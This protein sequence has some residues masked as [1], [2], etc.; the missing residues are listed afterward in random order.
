MGLQVW[1][2]GRRR[3][4]WAS[5]F[6]SAGAGAFPNWFQ[7]VSFLFSALLTMNGGLVPWI[8]VLFLIPC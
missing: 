1:K 3:F 8:L 5:K 6:G 7:F 2:C 4:K